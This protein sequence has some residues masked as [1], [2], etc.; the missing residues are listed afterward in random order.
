MLSDIVA[1]ARN[2]LHCAGSR[3]TSVVKSTRIRGLSEI[4]NVLDD[5]MVVFFAATTFPKITTKKT[6]DL[7]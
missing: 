3:S 1:T 6:T 7:I 5:Y 2:W 4:F